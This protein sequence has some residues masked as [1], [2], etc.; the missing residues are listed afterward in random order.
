MMYFRSFSVQ[1]YFLI[2]LVAKI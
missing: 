2:S 1:V